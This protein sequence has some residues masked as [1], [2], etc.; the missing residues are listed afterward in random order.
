LIRVSGFAIQKGGG[1]HHQ[2]P[3]I[4]FSEV[5]PGLVLPRPITLP[6]R[7]TPDPFH[8]KIGDMVEVDLWLGRD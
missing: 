7:I 3:E 8:L 4:D 6:G 5:E 2:A 1:Y